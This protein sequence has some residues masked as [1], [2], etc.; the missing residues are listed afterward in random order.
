M[1]PV[2]VCWT[3]PRWA[4]MTN[5]RNCVRK[6]D[7]M[8]D[9]P[10]NFCAP[11][12][13]VFLCQPPWLLS[14]WWELE[15][16]INPRTKF[17]TPGWLTVSLKLL[18]KKAPWLSTKDFS[19]FGVDLPLPLPCSWLF[20]NNWRKLKGLKHCEVYIIH[21]KILNSLLNLNLFIG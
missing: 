16:W 11:L 1:L 6:L 20:L 13:L 8:M 9:S 4:F 14:I 7:L 10:F 15:S 18:R 5:A 17:Y 3:Q 21:Q 19:L 12:Q 2:L